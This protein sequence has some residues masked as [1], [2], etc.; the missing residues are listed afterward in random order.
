MG[1]LRAAHTRTLRSFS[2]I[3][4]PDA[5]SG[6]HT[7]FRTDAF[8][9]RGRVVLLRATT[10]RRR[11]EYAPGT[12]WLSGSV[13][14]F[15]DCSRAGGV[16]SSAAGCAYAFYQRYCARVDHRQHVTLFHTLE[17]PYFTVGNI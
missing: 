12:A 4:V 16:Y 9:I 1:F 10:L 2:R 17:Q 5:V 8:N 7:A 3:P 11:D 14:F 15:A 6:T 13:I